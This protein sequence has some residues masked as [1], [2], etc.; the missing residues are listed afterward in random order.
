MD[1]IEEIKTVSNPN[2]FSKLK[3]IFSQ[4]T[5]F[6]ILISILLIGIGTSIYLV[7]EKAGY[8]DGRKKAAGSLHT[9]DIKTTPG[10]TDF[11]TKSANTPRGVFV[12]TD[13]DD[14]NSIDEATWALP[15]VDGVVVRAYWKDLNPEPEVYNWNLLDEQF[16]KA[17]QYNKRIKLM[18][19]PGFYSPE[20]VFSNTGVET[21]LFKVPQGPYRNEMKPLPLPWNETYLNL[22]FAFVD[23]V[24]ER[25][26]N[27]PNFS[28]ISATGPNS[29]NGELS[30]PR[31]PDDEKKWLEL[32][33]YNKTVLKDRLLNA[34]YKTIDKYCQSFSGKHFTISII[35]R[36]LPL[37]SDLQLDKTY[38]DQLVSYGA[39]K[40]QD[41]FGVQTNGLNG[42]P[43]YP[44]SKGQLAYWDLIRDYADKIFVGFQTEAPRN[45]F[46]KDDGANKKA[47]Y[48]QALLI[49][50][51][52]RYA[53]ILELYQTNI[54]DAELSPIVNTAHESLV[55]ITNSPTPNPTTPSQLG[56]IYGVIPVNE[57]SEFNLDEVKEIL[58]NPA[59]S[60]IALRERWINLEP[61]E[62]VYDFERIDKVLEEANITNKTVQLI[63]VPGLYSP[64]WLL[65]KINSCDSFSSANCGKITTN[66]PYGPGH[67]DTS[68]MPLVWDQT[69]KQAWSNFI[70]EVA[71]RYNGNPRIVSIAITGATSVS[72][73][74]SMPE[75]DNINKWNK[76]LGLFY[77]K[78][79]PHY[80]SN[81]IFVEEW[82][83][84]INNFAR[85]FQG[86]TLVVTMGSGLVNFYKGAPREAKDQIISFFQSAESG[87]NFKGVQTSG[88]KACRNNEGGIGE[89]KT[90]TASGIRG[91][92]QFNSS[93]SNNPTSMGCTDTAV[94]GRDDKRFCQ[95]KPQH[96][97][98]S[99]TEPQALKN[100][101]GVYFDQTPYGS[102]YGASNGDSKMTYLQIYKDDILFAN[103]HRD[104]NQV[105][106]EAGNR[107][108]EMGGN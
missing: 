89:I 80:N 25:Y 23:K 104:F 81:L 33:G 86:K 10:P 98:C 47:I 58:K 17:A 82:Q 68:E 16:A 2:I 93:V 20:Y 34:W 99:L 103:T 42:V 49:N 69:Y 14:T 78:D 43:I 106:T 65:R 95:T 66:V 22:W 31:E 5:K 88:M 71:R 27:N 15:Y 64:K 45:L 83:N 39:S 8:F 75:E 35:L 108:K 38:K 3:I 19:A 50:G 87:S 73:E 76:I 48:S 74:M 37:T 105:M 1:K 61:A 70:T 13:W 11:K 9:W 90:L 40:C 60:G 79:D 18:I 26:K 96:E 28:Y 21:A 92:G 32:S 94:C 57:K 44:V 41:T 53:D 51:L 12:L 24:S 107:I 6:I 62:G 101:L 72:A 56:V 55:N 84:A 67:G 77:P 54:Q 59:V 4:K 30:L 29:H 36:S 46:P 7:G 52:G 63:L 102:A 91:G 97:C 85:I 100:V